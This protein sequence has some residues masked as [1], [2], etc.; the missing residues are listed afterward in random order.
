MKTI[1]LLFLVLLGLT[2]ACQQEEES[3]NNIEEQDLT[4]N[5]KTASP[6]EV[7]GTPENGFNISKKALEQALKLPEVSTVRFILEV[8]NKQLQI[9]VA[10]AN[11]NG[12]ITKGVLA[13]PVSLQKVVN[14]LVAEKSKRFE[15]TALSKSVASH[16]LQPDEAV[17]FISG[18][19]QKWKG[20][21]LKGAIAYNDERIRYFS[22]PAAVAKHMLQ[23]DSKSVNL[24]WGVNPK[25]KFTTVF[26]P[27]LDGQNLLKTGIFIYEYSKPCPPTCPP[28]LD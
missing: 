8:E 20:S 2:V 23:N 16:I 11:P 13:T 6:K 10:G 18:W 22:M 24:V 3:Q 1:R 12:D 26:L 28:P 9:R 5:W 25:G 19:Q 7:F 27:E 4:L 17:D 21:A 15:T 14:K